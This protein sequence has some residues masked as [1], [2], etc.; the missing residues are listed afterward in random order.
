MTDREFVTEYARLTREI[1]RLD[2]AILAEVRQFDEPGALAKL[3]RGQLRSALGEM[4][5]L[6]R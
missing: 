5:A 4:S 3:L 6:V 1:W 2:A